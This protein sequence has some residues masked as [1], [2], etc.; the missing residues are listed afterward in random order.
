MTT[1]KNKIYVVVGAQ[2]GSESKGL[3]CA[4]LIKEHKIP[5]TVRTGS[6]N[7]GHTVPF[8]GRF[9]KNQQIPVGWVIENTEL[10]IGAGAFISPEVL[11]KE[12]SMIEEA[13]GQKLGTRLLIDYR[14]GTHLPVH[15]EQEKGMHERM[16]STGEGVMAAYIDKMERR[17]DYT[18]FTD[19]EYYKNNKDKN[20]FQV[21]DTVEYLNTMYDQGKDILIEGTQGCLLDLH[22]G[23]YPFTTSRQTNAAT[24]L[25]ECGLSPKCDLEVVLVARTYPIRVAGNSGPLP[26]EIS[27]VLLAQLVNNKRNACGMGGIIDEQ[28]L[29]KFDHLVQG[30]CYEEG[31]DSIED[32][33][34]E[35]RANHSYF[36][37][38][39]HK[40]AMEMMD[41]AE[42]NELKKFF[43]MTTV[44][45]KLRRIAELNMDD[46][47]YAVSIN[48][49]DYLVLN[50]MNY[51]FPSLYDT[52]STD[53]EKSPE[54]DQIKEYLDN[55]SHGL[56]TSIKY[57]NYSPNFI[58]KV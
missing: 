56:G 11:E 10:I 38:N 2:F 13:T 25:A 16:G 43:E 41:E 6:I 48:R 18:K 22:L 23:T 45:K 33:T 9:Y 12:I 47:K 21:I 5:I 1:N 3:V 14:C 50:F 17:N 19:T 34:T 29:S 51:V 24:W 46:L 20:H 44:T 53:W 31:V 30:L 26:N 4:E 8:K 15:Q 57:I 58:A 49:P 27:W 7:A 55:I 42:V 39:V 36:L 40:K 54:V 37:T 32:L 35:G 28:I 52:Q